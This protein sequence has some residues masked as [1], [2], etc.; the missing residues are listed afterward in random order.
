MRQRFKRRVFVSFFG[1]A[2]AIATAVVGCS[3]QDGSETSNEEQTQEPE[4]VP[5]HRH[6]AGVTEGADA[7]DGGYDASDGRA[8]HELALLL[9]AGRFCGSRDLHDCPL[10]GW[11]KRNATP[12]LD[13]GDISTIAVI[14]DQIVAL[15]PT[16]TTEDGGLLYE[17]WKSIAR[18]GANATRSGNIE[19]AKAACRG[20]HTQYRDRYHAILRARDL[21][22]IPVVPAAPVTTP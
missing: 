6:D 5:P 7:S 18:D 13:F 17:N 8:E 1:L 20:C 3:R 2:L 16:D 21:P 4:W 11:M 19:A 15:A 14:F 9:D 22:A 12:M 10:Q